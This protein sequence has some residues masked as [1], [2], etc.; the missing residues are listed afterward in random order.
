MS[1]L[2]VVVMVLALAAFQELAVRLR[3]KSI[4]SMFRDALTHG[5]SLDSSI[6]KTRSEIIDAKKEA[7]DAKVLA[8]GAVEAVKLLH[9]DLKRLK[10]HPLLRPLGGHGPTHLDGKG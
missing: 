4:T 1:W 10:E 6:R 7:S 3:W 2:Q 8:A 9:E 5:G